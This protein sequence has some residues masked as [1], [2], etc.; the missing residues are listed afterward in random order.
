MKK[1]KKFQKKLNDVAKRKEEIEQRRKDEIEK[2]SS[3]E[4]RFPGRV[5]ERIFNVW[6]EYQM[7]VGKINKADIK[8]IPFMYMEKINIW[9][10][11]VTFLKAKF[12]GKK[13]E[14]SF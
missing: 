13:P 7:E 14:K 2:L 11:G 5:S 6:L 4:N 3:F 12:I 10:K 1:L 9:N 8:E